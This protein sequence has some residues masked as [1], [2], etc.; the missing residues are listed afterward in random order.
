MKNMKNMKVVGSKLD[1]LRR[2]KLVG[3]LIYHRS[4]ILLRVIKSHVLLILFI[5]LFFLLLTFTI[6]RARVIKRL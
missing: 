5:S 3:V 4:K 2:A 1:N 6:P